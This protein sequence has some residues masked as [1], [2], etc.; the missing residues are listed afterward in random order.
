[1][2]AEKTIEKTTVERTEMWDLGLPSLLDQLV[3]DRDELTMRVREEV[4]TKHNAP[5]YQEVV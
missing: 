4:R 1:M 5:C 3:G 2:L